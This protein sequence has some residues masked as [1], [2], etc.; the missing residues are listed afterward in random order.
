MQSVLGL[1]APRQFLDHIF[2]LDL[3]ALQ[4]RGIRGIIVDLDNTLVAWN[5]GGAAP[6]EVADW[7]ATVRQRGF[8]ACILSNNYPERV[9][10]F[11]D[12]L[13]V[14]AIH[15][16]GKPRRGGFR[17]AMELMGTTPAET[18]VV[19]DQVFTDI[20]G[21]NRLGLHT[22]LVVPISKKEFVGTRLVRQIE[23]I[24]LAY[25]RGRGRLAR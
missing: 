10:A 4:E 3:V 24:L 8:E 7:L 6:G 19:G 9:A 15:R 17:R 18:A 20:L 23:R 22:I 13:P 14:P 2:F 11:S 21:G 12:R 1:L 16:A 5:R 25:L